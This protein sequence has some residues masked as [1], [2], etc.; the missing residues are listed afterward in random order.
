VKQYGSYR[1]NR[2]VLQGGL[3]KGRERITNQ[4]GIE[5]MGKTIIIDPNSATAG[6]LRRMSTKTTERQSGNQEQQKENTVRS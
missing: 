5:K 2:I 3:S 1:M 6:D 4:A